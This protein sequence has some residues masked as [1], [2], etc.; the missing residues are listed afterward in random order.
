MTDEKI[1]QLKHY[2][3]GSAAEAPDVDALWHDLSGRLPE[4]QQHPLHYPIRYAALTLGL[5]LFVGVSSFAVHAAQP[6]TPLYSL[7]VASED[8]VAKLSGRYDELIDNRSDDIIN[9]A[10]KKSDVEIKRAALEYKKA[11]E[12]AKTHKQTDNPQVKE[13]LK[14]SLKAAEEKLKMITPVD[15]TTRKV[16][17]E[18]I[19]ATKQTQ[20]EVKGVKTEAKPNEN[21]GPEIKPDNHVNE[22]NGNGNNSGAENSQRTNPKQ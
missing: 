12:D 21:K 6:N 14:K 7:R 11:L 1:Q 15:K 3:R 5:I 22:N 18:S 19:R 13:Q 10:Q 4:K 9:A 17:R 16:I 20:K 2:Y 8:I